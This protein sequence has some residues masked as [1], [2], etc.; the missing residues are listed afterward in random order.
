MC[1]YR[2]MIPTY[3]VQM[4]LNDGIYEGHFINF[5]RIGKQHLLSYKFGFGIY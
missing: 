5:A 3:V 2:A 4:F 1:E